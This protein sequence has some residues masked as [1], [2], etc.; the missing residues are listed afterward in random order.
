M[1]GGNST[2]D[3]FTCD[4]TAWY[5]INTSGMPNL[6][7]EYRLKVE[8]F[9]KLIREKKMAN[10]DYDF[11]SYF[12]PS[13]P[14]QNFWKDG[15][16]R[17]FDGEVSFY[18]CKFYHRTA[19]EKIRFNGDFILYKCH[20]P[21][22]LYIRNCIFEGRAAYSDSSLSD[23]S[24]FSHCTF[25]SKAE[26][27]AINILK[28]I[29][30]KGPYEGMSFN[31]IQ[32][33]IDPK[34]RTLFQNWQIN[35]PVEF[36]NII[37]SDTVQFDKVSFEK[38]SFR[39]CDITE[40]KFSNCSFAK[41]KSRLVFAD[42]EYRNINHKYN[43]LSNTYRQL[44]KNLMIAR[45]WVNAGDAYRSEMVMQRLSLWEEFKRGKWLNAFNLFVIGIYEVFS[46]YHQSLRRPIVFW[47]ALLAISATLYHDY[48]PTIKTFSEAC[49]ESIKVALPLISRIDVQQQEWI[50][51]V[52]VL[53]RMLSVLLL[54]FLGLSARARLRQ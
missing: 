37:F 3:I 50:F 44:K 49:K 4:K 19:F 35:S 25:N 39:S 46:G 38:V 51:Y 2:D 11:V 23:Q 27:T 45:D 40:V 24:A 52:K 15:E 13:F 42:D 17:I 41:K 14:D 21:H 53:E 6:L 33:S 48:D 1:Q 8:E 31:D 10:Q 34:N 28:T 29:G 12:F 7:D 20:I 18:D 43:E 22:K 47:L 30:Y 32:F 9:W 26:F 54:T 16:D 36:S 5:R